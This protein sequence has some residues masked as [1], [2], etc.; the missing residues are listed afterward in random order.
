MTHSRECNEVSMGRLVETRCPALD[1]KK[2]WLVCSTLV[3]VLGAGC[4]SALGHRP[5][6]G[7]DDDT[8][9]VKSMRGEI[10]FPN[11]DLAAKHKAAK[12]APQSFAPV[13]AY[14]RAVT[15]FCLGSLLDRTC[16]SCESGLQKYKR[17][18]DLN[19]RMWP[20]IEDVLPRLDALMS[21]QGLELAQMEQLVAVKG[22]LLWLVGRSMEEQTLIDSYALAH[23]DAVAVIRRRLELLREAGDVTELES[24]CARSRARVNSAPEP[25]R[26]ELLTSCVALHPD[27][28]D[29]RT[30]L[31]DYA[32]YLPNLATEEERLYRAHLEQRCVERVGEN[33]AACAQSCACNDK[34]SDKPTAK[35]K[36]TCRECRSETAQQM[37]VCK[38][39]GEVAPAPAPAARSKRAPARAPRPK[40]APA[41]AP[42]PKGS[43]ARRPKV[44][45]PGLEPQQAVL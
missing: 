34:P 13:F 31:L 38:K 23:P 30:D 12:A 18:S 27:N 8:D 20:V 15:D 4:S 35:C 41:P 33:G 17:R 32:K 11:Q 42:R 24:Q 16:T 25:A 36:R 1:L 2:R 5:R 21:V 10:R 9:E 7:A 26:V 3:F 43:P 44:V 22:R 29:G 39:I 19:P 45:D 6:S 37:R 14:A 28:T 40:A